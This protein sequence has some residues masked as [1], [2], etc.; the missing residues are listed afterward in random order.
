MNWY[1]TAIRGVNLADEAEIADGHCHL[2]TLIVVSEKDHVARV[3]MGIAGTK[4]LVADLRV[5]NFVECGHWIQLERPNDIN[6]TLKEF[7]Q[8]L[9]GK[10]EAGV[11]ST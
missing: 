8:D 2:P 3:D 4:E 1:K 10:T 11:T 7:A 9:F 5:K 6:D